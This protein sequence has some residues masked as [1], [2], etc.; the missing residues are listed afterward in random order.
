MGSTKRLDI[1]RHMERLHLAQ[2]SEPARHHEITELPR[3][4]RIGGPRVRIADR[5]REKLPEPPLGL[6]AGRG[7][8]DRRL[9]RRD[10][11]LGA[12]EGRRVVHHPSFLQK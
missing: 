7:D 2:I 3:R 9:I 8:Q 4:P 5:D 10:Q 1:G 6:V 12:G 11:A